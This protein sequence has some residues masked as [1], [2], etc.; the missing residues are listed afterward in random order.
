MGGKFKQAL[1]E[2]LE[3]LANSEE[4]KRETMVVATSSLPTAK[5]FFEGV[6]DGLMDLRTGYECHCNA[7]TRVISKHNR[8]VEIVAV[9]EAK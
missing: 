5:R 3:F 9:K 8:T 7:T 6:V 1:Q 2:A 4:G